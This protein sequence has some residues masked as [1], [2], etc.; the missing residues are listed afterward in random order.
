MD[1]SGRFMIQGLMVPPERGFPPD[2]TRPREGSIAALF[3]LSSQVCSLAQ[4]SRADCN[5]SN[6]SQS[7]LMR[8]T[9]R[10]ACRTSLPASR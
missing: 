7:A 9:Q 5:N 3:Y 2:S 10:R 1:H 8:S 4:Q 6:F